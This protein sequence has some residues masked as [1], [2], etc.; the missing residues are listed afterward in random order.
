MIKGQDRMISTHIMK[1]QK[2]FLHEIFIHGIYHFTVNKTFQR[3]D[4]S[5]KQHII[6]FCFLVC[7]ILKFFFKGQF[8]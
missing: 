2:R 4:F 6:V 1:I 8:V 3:Y 5:L 7:T